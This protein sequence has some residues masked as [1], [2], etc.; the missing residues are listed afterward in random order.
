MCNVSTLTKNCGTITSPNYP[1]NYPANQR[2][3]LDISVKPGNKV[4]ITFVDMHLE[5]S[6]GCNDDFVEV[7]KRCENVNMLPSVHFQVALWNFRYSR[8]NE[9]FNYELGYSSEIPIGNCRLAYHHRPKKQNKP[10]A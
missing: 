5:A 2:C 4:Q 1:E 3:D 6:P 8:S 9:T 7:S 10:R